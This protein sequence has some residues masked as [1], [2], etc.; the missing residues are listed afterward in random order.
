MEERQLLSAS[1]SGGS[2]LISAAPPFPTPFTSQ[3]SYQ[4]SPRLLLSN[5]SPLFS[6]WQF[7]HNL[8]KSVINTILDFVAYCEIV[9]T[10]WRCNRMQ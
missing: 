10:L 9:M 5:F 7:S 2:T 1:P 8:E 4:V 3:L 6:L